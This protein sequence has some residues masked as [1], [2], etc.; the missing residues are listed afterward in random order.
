MLRRNDRNLEN[1]PVGA[2]GLIP[3]KGCEELGAKV[4]DYLVKWRKE[5]EDLHA[6]DVAFNGYIR[7][8]YIIDAEVPRFG[9]GEAKGIIRE[10]VRGKDLYLMVDVLNYSLTYPMTGN[11]N[12]MS[13]LLYTSLSES[14][15]TIPKRPASC[16]GTGI[17]AIV[18]SAWFA[19]WKS[20]IIS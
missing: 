4:N 11:V 20:S 9:S 18:T 16:T 14:A 17:T 7:D 8:S 13:C 6:G 19:L 5:K 1:I 3:V 2:L 15:T 10:S 12:H